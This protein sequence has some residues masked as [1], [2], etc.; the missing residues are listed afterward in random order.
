MASSRPNRNDSG[1]LPE[2]DHVSMQLSESQRLAVEHIGSPALV[3]AGAGSGKTRTLTAKVAYL[4]EKGF[5]PE[6]IL[7]ITFTNKAAQEMK[8][9]LTRQTG[10]KLDRFPWVRT[11]HSACLQ[12]LK[13]H[14]ARAGFTPPVQILA[15]YQQLKT[16]QEIAARLNIDKK[17]VPDLQHKVSMAKN[18]GDPLEWIA[19][20]PEI[21]KVRTREVFRHYEAALKQMNAVDFDNI[22]LL[23]RDLLRDHADIREEYR[24]LFQFI[25]VDEYQDSNNL[26]EELTRLLLGDHRN[27]FCVGDDWQAVYGFRG[28]NVNH[29]LRFTKTYEGAVTYRLEEN[30]RSADEIVQAAGALI[31][32]NPHKMDKHCFSGKRGGTVELYYFYNETEEARWVG[33]KVR[34]LLDSGMKPDQ[35]AVIYRTKFCSL[36]FEKMFRAMG[37]PYNML[38]SKGFF[39]RME[40]LDLNSYL[41]A[42]AFS[43]DDPSFERIINTP[44][45][46]I[47]PAMIK[48]M[49][50]V[51]ENGMSLQDAARKMV[52]ERLLSAKVHKGISDLL[53]LLDDIRDMT[54]DTA[55]RT[56][57]DRT[58]YMAYLEQASKSD[59]GDFTARQENIEELL[60]TAGQKETLVDYLE[61]AALVRED[62]EDDDDDSGY[63]VNLATVHASKGLEFHTVFVV[64]C[65]E[66][67]FPHWKSMESENEIEEERRLMYVAMT[68]AERQ[69][70]ITSSQYR[71]GRETE[72][73]RFMVEVADAID[74]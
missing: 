66:E 42:S 16:Y 31:E 38:G 64:G 72:T 33:R 49:Q 8:T 51:R 47:G 62:K 15:G 2:K 55:L 61:E 40:I 67:L 5:Q 41:T 74:L 68:R 37:I 18:H 71:R 45:R 50:Q 70:Y 19:R 3:V 25:L 54:P 21:S 63:G 57:I 59:K 39:E 65:E 73:S 44:R 27:L 1:T 69:L 13:K 48:K 58:G 30:Y 46:G 32:N 28:S 4:L 20:L 24:S 52:S 14:A 22:L 53:Q 12:I 10:L 34:V 60:Y 9:R 17:Q 36:A 6:R 35:M 23:V 56:V 26:Q 43:K 11:Y 7:A 29:F